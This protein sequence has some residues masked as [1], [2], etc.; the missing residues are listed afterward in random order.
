MHFM[1]GQWPGTSRALAEAT[2]ANSARF[3]TGAPAFVQ[4]IA[5]DLELFHE[6]KT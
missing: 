6:I 3:A 2:P 4:L 5:Q 1:Y